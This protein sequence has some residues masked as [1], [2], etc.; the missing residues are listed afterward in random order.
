MNDLVRVAALERQAELVREL[1]SLKRLDAVPITRQH[2]A[3]TSD[4][5]V[6]QF[7]PLDRTPRT[8]FMLSQM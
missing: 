4:V 3:H 6:A 8:L 7:E 5:S 2:L 1:P